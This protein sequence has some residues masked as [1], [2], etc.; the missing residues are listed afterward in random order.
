VQSLAGGEVTYTHGGGATAWRLP[1]AA[2]LRI[3]EPCTEHQPTQKPTLA[4]RDAR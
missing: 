3:C 4:G 2:F 1:V